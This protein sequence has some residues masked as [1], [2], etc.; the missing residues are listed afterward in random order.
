[1]A[2]Q[3]AKAVFHVLP[4]GAQGDSAAA[5]RHDRLLIGHAFRA[6]KRPGQHVVAVEGLARRVF[7]LG[8]RQA[9]G[10][11]LAIPVIEIVGDLVQDFLLTLRIQMKRRQAPPQVRSPLRHVPLRRCG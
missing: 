7:S 11:K 4:D 8:L 6:R 2:P 10:T 5:A 3:R 1:M 9:G